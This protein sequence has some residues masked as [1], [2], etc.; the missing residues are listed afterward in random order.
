MNKEELVNTLLDELENEEITQRYT[1]YF[2]DNINEETVQNLIDKLHGC[3]AIDLYFSTEGGYVSSMKVLV[4]F[5]NSCKDLNIYLTHFVASAGT[6]LLT[7]C[8]HPIILTE[9]L[10]FILFHMLDAPVENQF[11]KHPVDFKITHEQLRELN[12]N[13]ANKYKK[14][15]LNKK[16][17]TEFL[18]GNDV[19]LYRKDFEKLN[20]NK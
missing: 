11:R 18:K 1:Y 15:G 16:E 6:F 3:P 14:L 4:H 12:N 8:I 5:L 17:I 2:S 13:W 9:D 10:D 20:L 7:D 19:V